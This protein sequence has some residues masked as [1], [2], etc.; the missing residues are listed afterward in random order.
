MEWI[1]VDRKH[2]Q[3]AAPVLVAAGQ[4]IA[5][6]DWDAEEKR[7]RMASREDAA[8]ILV[9]TITHWMHLPELP[10]ERHNDWSRE[11]LLCDGV[12]TSKRR[13]DCS[14]RL[15]PFYIEVNATIHKSG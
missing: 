8:L 4:Y 14:G 3:S 1:S 9:E 10:K 7:F 13:C 2:P 5:L 12:V 6:A 15:S 11:L